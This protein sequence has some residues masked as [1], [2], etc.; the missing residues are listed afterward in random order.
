MSAPKTTCD[1]Q[2]QMTKTIAGNRFL[3]IPEGAN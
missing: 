2:E 1:P 3:A